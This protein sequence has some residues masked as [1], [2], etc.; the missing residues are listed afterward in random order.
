[1]FGKRVNALHALLAPFVSGRFCPPSSFV[2]MKLRFIPPQS[3][4]GAPFDSRDW[5]AS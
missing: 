2:A 5:L 3:S 4:G 1:M